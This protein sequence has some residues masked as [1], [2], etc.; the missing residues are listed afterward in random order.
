MGNIKYEFEE[1]V[2]LGVDFSCQSI[3]EVSKV[4]VD[5]GRIKELMI[6][7]NYKSEKAFADTIGVNQRTFNAQSRGVNNVTLDVVLSILQTF[8]NVSAE[9]LLSGK[10]D[11]FKGDGMSVAQMDRIQNLKDEINSK[12]KEILK[13]RKEKER[14]FETIISLVQM[15]RDKDK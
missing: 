7:L 14:C 5:F 4:R 13:L 15:L 9:W 8:G 11:M 10:G 1:P 3:N 2:V 6:A 12:D